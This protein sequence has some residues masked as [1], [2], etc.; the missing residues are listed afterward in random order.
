MPD[1]RIPAISGGG[2]SFRG[3]AAA[4]ALGR[5]AQLIEHVEAGCL[6]PRSRAQWLA[7]ARHA[8]VGTVRLL[9][10]RGALPNLGGTR[11]GD[12]SGVSD[13]STTLSAVGSSGGSFDAKCETVALLKARGALPKSAMLLLGGSAAAR[14][15]KL[16]QLLKARNA[17]EA[18]DFLELAAGQG[19]RASLDIGDDRANAVHLGLG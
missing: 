2:V 13:A 11:A 19:L 8:L 17:R 14:A 16:H 4:A 10:E 18:L 7:Q 9:L 3:V 12:G 1:K 6:S 5:R 15:Q